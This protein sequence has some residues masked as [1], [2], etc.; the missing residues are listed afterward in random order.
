M[1]L[2]EPYVFPGIVAAI[3]SFFGT[4]I[5]HA[6]LP[7][8]TSLYLHGPSWFY[9]SP[10]GRALGAI[11]GYAGLA[12]LTIL[13]AASIPFIA[14]KLARDNGRD[15]RVAAWSVFLFPASWYIFAVSI[16]TIAATFLVVSLIVPKRTGLVF[17]AVASLLH[18]ALIP[19]ALAIAGI[20]HLRGVAAVFAVS[21][22][23]AVAIVYMVAT[24]YGLLVSRHVNFLTFL[25]AGAATFFVGIIP[26]I[27]LKRRAPLDSLF[28]TGIVVTAI[29]GMESAVQ[30]HFQPRYCL[31][32]A[33]ILAAA[34]A[35]ELSSVYAYAK[36][37]ARFAISPPLAGTYTQERG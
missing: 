21:L 26:A 25:W 31:P 36:N 24:P 16:D 20:R 13:C 27:L 2:F 33:L 19:A 29:G 5:L 3:L 9:P 37:G 12:S 22:C 6:T 34:I 23:G 32:G 30:Q 17:L 14:Y 4:V 28:L 35:P 18:L 10:L 7:P 1:G 15:G 11:G 8:D